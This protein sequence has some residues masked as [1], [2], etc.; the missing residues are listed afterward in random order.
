MDQVRNEE[1]KASQKPTFKLQI[2]KFSAE[3]GNDVKW[4]WDIRLW[5][6]LLIIL[7]IIALWPSPKSAA[8]AQ[9]EVP[10]QVQEEVQQEIVPED[11]VPV[12]TVPEA[13]NP[14]AEALARLADTVGAGRTDNVK[15]VIMWVAINRSEDRANGYGKSLEE[16]IS[17]ANQWQFY[18]EN[19]KYGEG[20]Y[21]LA[22]DVLKVARSNGLRPV[23]N[24]MLWFVLNDNGSITVRNQ[25]NFNK[26]TNQKTY[27]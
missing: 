4:Y 1:K 9:M 16:E 20:T 17:R 24:D 2:G 23:E 22:Q 11:T 8:P 10:Q 6:P 26:N 19:A 5:A 14:E 15:I 13:R 27:K 25:F 3:I 12:E 7:F 21:M 18:D